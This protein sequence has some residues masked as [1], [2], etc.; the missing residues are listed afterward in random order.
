MP[1]G[2]ILG[3]ILLL[4]RNLQRREPCGASSC[5]NPRD[6][7]I[8]RSCIQAR[9][10]K[11]R[12]QFQ[13][14][15]AILILVVRLT[16][17]KQYAVER[18]ACRD[19]RRGCSMGEYQMRSRRQSIDAL[20]AGMRGLKWRRAQLHR[21]EFRRCLWQIGWTLLRGGPPR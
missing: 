19:Q 7:S 3:D 14:T 8:G 4:G 5:S 9:S 17:G 16:C 11:L 12:Y 2:W 18:R 20:Q 21:L 1:L 15:F 10:R 13:F 6:L